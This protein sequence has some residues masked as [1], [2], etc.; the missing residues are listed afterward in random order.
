MTNLTIIDSW[1][2]DPVE[3]RNQALQKQYK[4]DSTEGAGAEYEGIART[5]LDPE[6]GIGDCETFFRLTL[7]QYTQPTFIHNDAA[8]CRST[9]ILYLNDTPY[10]M[11]NGTAF[12]MHKESGLLRAPTHADLKILGPDYMTKLIEDGLDESCWEMTEFC[13]MKFN[14]FLMFDSSLWHSCYPRGGWGTDVN[15]GRLIQ[16]YLI[17]GNP[18]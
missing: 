9:G 2:R 6:D 13:P 1:L 10:I 15:N 11:Q 16:V 12:W 4:K 18:V 14:R 5:E 8:L 7:P 17:E 3:R